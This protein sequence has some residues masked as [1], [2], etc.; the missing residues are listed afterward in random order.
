MKIIM[1]AVALIALTAIFSAF[2]MAQGGNT[3]LSLRDDLV[4]IAVTAIL[5]CLSGGVGTYIATQFKLKEQNKAF[6]LK[7]KEIQSQIDSQRA[8]EKQNQEANLRLRYV[9]P[10]RSTTN[11]LIE[12]ISAIEGRINTPYEQEVKNWFRYIKGFCDSNKDNESKK[13]FFTWCH[14]EGLFS[15]STLHKSAV[16]FAYADQIFQKSPFSEL[17]RAYAESLEKQLR[18]VRGAF[19]GVNG[20][21]E[22]SQDVIGNFVTKGDMVT[23]YREFCRDFAFD[24]LGTAAF[25]R[26]TDFFH[27]DDLLTKTKLSQVRIALNHLQQFLSYMDKGV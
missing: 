22:N 25:L 26:I 10:L 24:D 2:G 13:K 3:P 9:N 15:M 4:K 16:F 21:Y 14:Y 17:D 18:E 12:K 19:G 20:I 1:S 11:D 23:D 5:G 7:V 8:A 27:R 6:S